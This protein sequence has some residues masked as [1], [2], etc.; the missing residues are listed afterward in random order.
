MCK[1]IYWILYIIMPATTG[2]LITVL[3]GANIYNVLWW[4]IAIPASIINIAVL[5]I[6]FHKCLYK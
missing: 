1:I 4:I 3:F 2:I 5:N 6:L